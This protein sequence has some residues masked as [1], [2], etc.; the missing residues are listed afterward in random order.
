MSNLNDVFGEASFGG[1]R[2]NWFKFPKE[3]GSLILRILPPYGS[4]REKGR[5]N[6]YYA[7]HFGYRDSKNQLRPFQSCEVINRQNKMVEIAD[8]ASER[9][10]G[11]KMAQDKA[12]LENNTAVVQ[13]LGE[14]LKKFNIKKNYYMN[15]MDLNGKIGVFSIPHRMMESLKEEITRLQSKGVN[16]ISVNDGRFF[17]FTRTGTGANTSHKVA[18]YQETQV[19]NGVEV[20]IDKKSVLTPDVA[21]RIQFE[22]A[23]LGKIY[24]APTSE[25]IA[26]IVKGGAIE[27]EAVFAKYRS[28]SDSQVSESV[29]ET[30][31]ASASLAEEVPYE[32]PAQEATSTSEP[33]SAPVASST[34]NPI[35][36]MSSDDFLKSMGL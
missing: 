18:V 33:P 12:K 16:P 23:D 11:I 28:G 9:I 17:V 7:I 27:L 25:E 5:W 20:S 19:M 34:A 36:D 1:S 14:E 29:T 10:K 2:T 8:P 35:A 3:G 4:L 31:S 13:R 15:V 32:Y 21:T 22:G 30:V 6:Q 24:I 26:S